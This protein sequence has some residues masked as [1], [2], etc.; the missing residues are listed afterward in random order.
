MHDIF[1]GLELKGE[2][3]SVFKLATEQDMERL[4]KLVLEVDN[5][6]V[7]EDTSKKHIKN[8]VSFEHV[9]KKNFF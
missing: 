3:F 2:N 8:K 4:Q 9:L 1:E 7:P 5:S 6:L